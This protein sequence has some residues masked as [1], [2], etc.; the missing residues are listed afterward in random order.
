[1]QRTKTPYM[2]VR[3]KAKLTSKGQITLPIEV[4]RRLGVDAGDFV[5]FE[6]TD[7]GIALTRE[8]EPGVFEKWAGRFRT[9]KGQTAQEIDRWLGT[10]RG[11]GDE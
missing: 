8:Y 2:D 3:S 11:H 6:L 4:R 5:T 1:V 9:G 10:I 7:A